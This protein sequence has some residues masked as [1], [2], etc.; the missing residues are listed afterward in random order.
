MQINVF[1]LFDYLIIWSNHYQ[2]I[3]LIH[4]LNAIANSS[5]ELKRNIILKTFD[6]NIR[7]L[8]RET[9]IQFIQL[10]TCSAETFFQIFF[11]FET[12]KLKVTLDSW[13]ILEVLYE[14][15]IFSF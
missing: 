11:I 8:F 13:S 4:I 10:E 7:G 1:S 9:H 12:L 15:T 2:I 5:F 14:S 6:L 3:F